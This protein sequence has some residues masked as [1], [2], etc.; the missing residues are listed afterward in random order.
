MLSDLDLMIFR[1]TGPT[2]YLP[3]GE[4]TARAHEPRAIRYRDTRIL[5]LPVLLSEGS[6]NN[7]FPYQGLFSETV[8]G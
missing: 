5:P 8:G 1:D 6:K 4:L 7:R 2:G 3:I